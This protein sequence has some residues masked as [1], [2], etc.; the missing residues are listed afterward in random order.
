MYRESS[1]S[2][3]VQIHGIERVPPEYDVEAT[4]GVVNRLHVGNGVFVWAMRRQV[5]LTLE[6]NIASMLWS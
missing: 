2:A 4:E 1:I 6:D 3:E 5:F